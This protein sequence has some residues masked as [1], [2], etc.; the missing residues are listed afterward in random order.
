MEST[1]YLRDL[2]QR[3][4]DVTNVAGESTKRT[5]VSGPYHIE[6]GPAGYAL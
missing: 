2:Y 5:W 4:V 6:R 1:V 3:Y